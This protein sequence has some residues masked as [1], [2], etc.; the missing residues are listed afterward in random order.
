MET[1]KSKNDVLKYVLSRD[2][3]TGGFLPEKS[4]NRFITSMGT[5][6]TLLGMARRIKLPQISG[7]LI[8][9]IHFTGPIT[10]GATEYTYDPKTHDVAPSMLE[11]NATKFRA[12][13]S[14]SVDT[15]LNNIEYEGFEKT[16]MDLTE[17]QIVEDTEN[18]A[19]N[20]DVAITAADDLSE[21]LKQT[22]GWEV[23]SQGGHLLDAGGYTI[24]KD[25]WAAM[26]QKMPKRYR[27]KIKKVL[28]FFV[29]DAVWMDWLL[30]NS[31]RA[32]SIGTNAMKGNTISPFGFDIV[33]VPLF[34]EDLG[35]S[36]A[37]AT[38]AWVRSFREAYVK[39]VEDKN[40]QIRI[41]V[42]AGGEVQR[43]IAPGVYIPEQIKAEL[44]TKFGQDYFSVD[45]MGRLIATSTTTGGA[46][47]FAFI[48]CPNSALDT[49][50]FEVGI[51]TGAAAAGAGE[52]Q[53]GSYI[54]LTDP[55]NLIY[56]I[57]NKIR[58]HREYDHKKDSIE[59]VWYFYHGFNIEE[60]DM[61]VRCDNVK[62]RKLF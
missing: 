22:D 1:M 59:A 18:V 37:A 11:L 61:F 40:D 34:P 12:R 4:A 56:G 5:Y 3:V 6:S 48:D 25:I 60:L 39:I 38:A 27:K 17:E 14:I 50:G 57:Y 9:K 51:T 28:K 55:L 15:L 23:M 32:D 19:I 2:F 53:D 45:A 16:F 21:L 41:N 29:S 33:P 43:Q 58:F 52:T 13:S 46:S 20:G 8:P 42:D 26:Y 35:I 30:L 54:W 44:N 7:N 10:T 31:G 24:Q 47:T 62:T 49:L 36:T